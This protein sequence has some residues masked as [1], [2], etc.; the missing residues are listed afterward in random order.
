MEKQS[1]RS[2]SEQFAASRGTLPVTYGGSR[3]YPDPTGSRGRCWLSTFTTC[4]AGLGPKI[5]LQI[6][7][8]V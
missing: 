1:S 6:L 2:V 3:S 5:I 7:W 4:D 8:F